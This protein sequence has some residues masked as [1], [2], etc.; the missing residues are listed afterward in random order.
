MNEFNKFEFRKS[1]IDWYLE[2]KRN[3]PWRETSDPYK[4]WVSEIML[5]Q[6][7]VDTV[8]PYYNRFIEAFPTIEDLANA[9]EEK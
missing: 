4:I 2:E 6:T 5:Q 9:D 1:L 3:L 8:I 7:R